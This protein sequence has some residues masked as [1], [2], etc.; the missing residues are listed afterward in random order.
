MI[1]IEDTANKDKK[2]IA[3]NEYWKSQGI[4]VL[5]YGLPCCDYIIANDAVIDVI[6]RKKKRG[7]LPHKMDFLGTYNVAVDTKGT[8]REI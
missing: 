3:K 7:M 1:L 8:R 6:E 5:R 2:H 4:E